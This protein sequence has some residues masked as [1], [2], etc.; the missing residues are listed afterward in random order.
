MSDTLTKP[1]RAYITD[2]KVQLLGG[3]MT[4][5]VDVFSVKS[6]KGKKSGASFVS[7]CPTC[8]TPTPVTQFSDCTASTEHS[9][10]TSKDLAKAIQL[11]DGSLEW[12]SEEEQAVV[13]ELEEFDPKQIAFDIVPAADVEFHMRPADLAYRIRPHSKGDAAPYLVLRDYLRKTKHALVGAL[14][15]KAGDP[16]RFYRAEVWHDQIV[17]QSLVR[18][19]DLAPADEIT[20]A[21]KEGLLEALGK[22]LDKL[23]VD[24]DPATYRNVSRERIAELAARKAENPGSERPDNVTPIRPAAVVDDGSDLLAALS[25]MADEKPAKKPARAKQTRKAS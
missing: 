7:A 3:L 23:A 4:I 24:F 2:V 5:S 22:N 14:R 15:L 16:V 8:P 21:Y 10:F 20:G 13:K 1:Q 18:P 25:A 17:L 9:H 6:P 12:V 11:E 19:D